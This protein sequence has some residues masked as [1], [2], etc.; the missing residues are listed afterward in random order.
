MSRRDKECHCNNSKANENSCTNNPITCAICLENIVDNRQYGILENC[1]HSFCHACIRRWRTSSQQNRLMCPQCR[2][3]SHMMFPSR[4]W[5]NTVAE[6]KQMINEKLREWSTK[7]CRFFRGGTGFCRFGNRCRFQHSIDF[8]SPEL[9]NQQH[10]VTNFID[11]NCSI[12]AVYEQASDIDWNAF[13]GHDDDIDLEYFMPVLAS[14][15]SHLDSP[16][17]SMSVLDESINNHDNSDNENVIMPCWSNYI[18][19]M[20]VNGIMDVLEDFEDEP[21]SDPDDNLSDFLATNQIDWYN[22]DLIDNGEHD[23]SDGDDCDEDQSDNDVGEPYFDENNDH[24]DGS[25]VSASTVESENDASHEFSSGSTKY[26][27]SDA[28]D[29]NSDSHVNEASDSSDASLPY[30]NASSEIFSLSD[31]DTTA[32]DDDGDSISSFHFAR[33]ANRN[34]RCDDSSIDQNTDFELYDGSEF[35]TNSLPSDSS[36]YS[37]RIYYNSNYSLNS[38]TDSSDCEQY[39]GYYSSSIPLSNSEGD[40]MSSISDDSQQ[41]DS[42]LM[43]MTSSDENNSDQISSVEFRN[44]HNNT[45]LLSDETDSVMDVNDMVI[46]LNIHNCPERKSMQS[47]RIYRKDN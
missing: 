8:Q 47:E 2:T 39:S 9:I 36:L 30:S 14:A 45:D 43:A 44:D 7:P 15:D 19:D 23:F 40:H 3:M 28:A 26:E 41:D 42:A 17:A 27:S 22:Y 11:D 5:F 38:F 29:Q 24:S 33:H 34:F 46:R 6:K 4:V 16:T 31:V 1:N 20:F 10:P 21:S 25:I 37:E 12:Q 35:L 13:L 32:D 18:D